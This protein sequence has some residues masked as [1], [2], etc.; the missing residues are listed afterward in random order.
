MAERDPL[1]WMERTTEVLE[2]CMANRLLFGAFSL[3]VGLVIYF[4]Y[5]H[6]HGP[7]M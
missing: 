2:G 1:A 6:F 4:T 5:I 3:V 7:V